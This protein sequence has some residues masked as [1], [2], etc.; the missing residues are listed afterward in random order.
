MGALTV[1]LREFLDANAVGVLCHGR[2]HGGPRQSLFTSCA[3]ETG[4]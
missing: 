2:P 1:E 4:C 3:T